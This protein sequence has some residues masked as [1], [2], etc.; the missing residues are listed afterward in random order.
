MNFMVEINCKVINYKY[1]NVFKDQNLMSI[2]SYLE[3]F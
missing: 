2:S 1:I 3:W